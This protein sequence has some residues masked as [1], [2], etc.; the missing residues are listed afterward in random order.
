MSWSGVF[1]QQIDGRAWRYGQKEQVFVYRMVALGTTDVSMSSMAGEKTTFLGALTRQAKDTMLDTI[2]KSMKEIEEEEFDAIEEDSEDDDR[3]KRKRKAPSKKG[4]A[5]AVEHSEDVQIGK[6]TAGPKKKGKAKSKKQGDVVEVVEVE[7]APIAGPSKKP[8]P[9][10]KSKKQ[11]DPVEVPQD[12]VLQSAS[13]TKKTKAKSG[14]ANTAADL[15][16]VHMTAEPPTAVSSTTTGDLVE[17][18]TT[19]EQP[20]ASQSTSTGDLVEIH[21]IDE[22]PAGRQLITTGDLVEVRNADELTTAGM[23]LRKRMKPK[24]KATALPA[25][26]SQDVS[27]TPRKGKGRAKRQPD[28]TSIILEQPH[29]LDL[30]EVPPVSH[31]DPPMS[32]DFDDNNTS[33]PAIEE[34]QAVT[35][36]ENQSDMDLVSSAPV[37]PVHQTSAKRSATSPLKTPPKTLKKKARVVSPTPFSSPIGPGESFLLSLGEDAYRLQSL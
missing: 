34:S 27:S 7:K 33:H 1:Q 30:V 29:P 16:E 26:D 20:T 2:L 5:K 17:V 22:S 8:K 35:V 25:D 9:K 23:S 24:P 32:V 37:T 14:A 31:H 18:H 10:A 19:D 12:T 3:P 28:P 11:Q 21:I 15:V 13:G 6:E 36:D 4:K